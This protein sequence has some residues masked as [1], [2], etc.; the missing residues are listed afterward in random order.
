V[1]GQ[2]PAPLTVL[3]SVSPAFRAS[4]SIE[5]L[6]VLYP[7]TYDREL[8][9]AYS[10]LEAAVFQLKERRLACALW[11]GSI[12]GRCSVSSGFR[13]AAYYQRS[14]PSDWD[15]SSASM[16]SCCTGSRDQVSVTG[17]LLAMAM[18]ETALPGL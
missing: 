9:E 18:W 7:K 8:M 11:I 15:A 16:V 10:R 17:S 2:R 5:R 14:M 4:M 1:S 3:S 6:A 13:P 12:S